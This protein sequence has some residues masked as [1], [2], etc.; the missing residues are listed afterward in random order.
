MTDFKEQ[1]L[2]MLLRRY[3]EEFKEACYGKDWGRAKY[4][5]DTARKLVAG[6]PFGK[7]ERERLA[8]QLFGNQGCED[9]LEKPQ[10]GLF[11]EALADRAY[12][13]CAIK[14]K[15]AYENEAMSRYGEP[16]KYY[17]YPSY[18]RKDGA[19]GHRT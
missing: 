5:Y 10:D 4:L 2:D 18:D 3:P 17:A 13:E 11:P 15:K 6:L 12:L 9:R 7:E 8:R 19:S 16:P 14:L 1:K